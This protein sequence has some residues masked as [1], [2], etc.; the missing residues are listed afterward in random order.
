[1]PENSLKKSLTLTQMI[2]LAAGGMIAAWMVEIKYWFEL[3]GPGSF[4]ALVTCGLFVLPLCFIY[5]ELT[6]MLPYSGGENIWISNAF[7]W[8]AGW[9]ACWAVILLYVMAM[10]TVSY[11]I[12][13]MMGYFYPITFIQTKAIALAILI[14]WFFLTNKELKFL[15]KIQNFL[16]WST[17]VV[18]I[19]ASIIFITNDAWNINNLK[20]FFTNGAKG[21]SAAVALLIMKFIGF[22]LIPQLSEE[23]DF[24]K[25]KLWIAFLASLGLTTLIYGFAIIGVG[26]IVT[27]EW[28][29]ATDIVDPRVA[30]I[31]G[32]HWLGVAVVVMGIGT[33]ITTLSGFWVAAARTFFG[34]A[35]QRQFTAKLTAIN[36]DGQPYKAN[37]IVGILS[38]YFT[39]FA[40]DTWVNYIYTIYGLTAGIVY[41]MVTLS[42][43]ILRKK[44]PEWERP[45][46]VKAATLLGTISVFFT[47]YVIYTSVLAMNTGAWVVFILYFAL[48]IPF[49]AYAKGKQKKD[50]ANWAPIILSPDYVAQ[51]A[52]TKT[53]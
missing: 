34:A 13:S 52:S 39:V 36:K 31:V 50:P 53:E 11:G 29:A 41:L 17:L 26:G 30:D 7:N 20:P 5:T 12:A 10:P 32:L 37:I 27:S 6:S 28:I 4:A 19:L 48:G 16:F 24:P 49:W 15:A 44:H 14:L 23:A 51:V 8:S 1:M 18:S 46:K 22:D 43:I 33:C 9:F 3:S 47:I 35:Q 38:I 25:N 45:Y 2:A 40:P 21:Y 42:F